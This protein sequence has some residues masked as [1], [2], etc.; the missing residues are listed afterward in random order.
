MRFSRLVTRSIR[1]RCPR[2]GKRPLF[3]GW[4]AM[5]DDCSA[6]HLSFVR[7]PGF[8]LGTIYFNYGLT[9]LIATIAYPLAVF[10]LKVPPQTAVAATLAF[11]CLFPLWFFRYARSLWLGFDHYFDPQRDA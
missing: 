5:H 8:Y 9:A 3:R 7:E 10:W 2:C 4:L 6:C 1:L 11:V